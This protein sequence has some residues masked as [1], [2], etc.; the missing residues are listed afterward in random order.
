M[1]D[2]TF[3]FASKIA[4]F[5]SDIDWDKNILSEEDKASVAEA[6]EMLYDLAESIA[7]DRASELYSTR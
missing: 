4:A 3:A 6:I 5:A 1:S 2:T 7:G